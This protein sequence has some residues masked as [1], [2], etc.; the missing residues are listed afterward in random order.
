MIQKYDKLWQLFAELD[1]CDSDIELV[2]LIAIQRE[3][4]R[5]IDSFK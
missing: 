1:E 2:K 5:L 4:E 3:V